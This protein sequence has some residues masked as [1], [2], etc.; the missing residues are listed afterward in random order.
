MYRHRVFRSS[1][2][3]LL[4]ALERKD[5]SK[6][7]QFSRRRFN[8]GPFTAVKSYP[9]LKR[10]VLPPNYKYVPDTRHKVKLPLRDVLRGVYIFN[11]YVRGCKFY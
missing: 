9:T 7:Y 3:F 6:S 5:V 11:T 8:V 2:F 10:S 1:F 4:F